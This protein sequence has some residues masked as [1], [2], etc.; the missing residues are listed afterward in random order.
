VL[1]LPLYWPTLRYDLFQDDFLL[2]RPWAPEHLVASWFGGWFVSEHR[3]FYRP[4]AVLLYRAMF[5]P[6]GLNTPVLHILPFITMSVVAWMLGRFVRRETD[7]WSL[8]VVATAI[9]VVHPTGTVAV[10]PW[11]VNQ[12]QGI[13]SGALLAALLWWQTARTRAWPWSLPLI[14][15]IIVGAF[16]KETGLVIPAVLVA[17]ALARG[18]WTRDL[19][20]PPRW[21]IVGGLVVFV[22][23]N[24]WRIWILGG[25]GGG[26]GFEIRLYAAQYYDGWY[27]SLFTPIRM[28]AP[29]PLKWV[30]AAVSAVL[31]ACGAAALLRRDRGPA[32]VLFLTGALDTC[33]RCPAH[34]H[35]L[36]QGPADAAYRRCRADADGRIRLRAGAPA[37]TDARAVGRPRDRVLWHVHTVVADRHRTLQPV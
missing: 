12:Y 17:I 3:D 13:V 11:L 35:H 27:A 9:G 24:L 19:P 14:V 22:G 32:G 16:T 33:G 1:V 23:L 10:G 36:L 15:P 25:L 2:L 29:A 34:Q 37:W 18:W 31:V 8:A 21:F 6:F 5:Y 4:F 28:T 26:S 7:S 30:F 20:P